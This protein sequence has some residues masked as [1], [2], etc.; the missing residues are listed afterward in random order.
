MYSTGQ[1]VKG[2]KNPRLTAWELANLY[3]R[4]VRAKRGISVMSRDWDNLVILDACRYDMFSEMN[5]IEGN[6]SR[7]ISQASTTGKF[8]DANFTAESYPESIYVSA[9]PHVAVHDIDTKFFD[10][11]RLWET[12]WDDQLQTVHPQSVVER[13]TEVHEQHPNKRLIVHFI[14]PH[15]PFIGETGQEIEHGTMTGNGAISDERDQDS[16]WRRLEKGELSK[17]VVWKA[18]RENLEVVFPHVEELLNRLDGKSVVTSDHGNAFGRFGVYGHPPNR[19]LEELVAVPWLSIEGETRRK[20]T[21]GEVDKPSEVSQTVE[22]RLADLG[23]KS[24]SG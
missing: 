7:V 22:R 11:V 15:Y 9:N 3:H 12:S 10:R 19:F 23:Y 2:I 18:Y 14:Q 21:Q 13:T 24:R 17:E 8:L 6:L 4:R 1:I 20:I 16:V 5:R